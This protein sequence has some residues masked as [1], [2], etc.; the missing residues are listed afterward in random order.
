MYT[1][2]IGGVH[3]P[4]F[5][6][7]SSGKEI[8]SLPLPTKVFIG[9]SQHLGKP[10]KPLVKPKQEVRVGQLIGEADGFISANIHSSVSGVVK[11]VETMATAIGSL[12][13][14][15]VIDVDKEKT[16]EDEK[17]LFNKKDFNINELDKEYVLK[18]IKDAGIV[19]LGGATFPSNVKLSPPNGKAIEYLILNGAECEPYLTAD[20]RLMLKKTKEIIIGTEIIAKLLGVK[21]SFI[22]IE[23][24]K[25]D[26][27]EFF[28]KYLKEGGIK[29]IEVAPLKTKYPQGGEKQLIYAITKREVPSGKLPLDVGSVVHNVGTVFAVYEALHFDKPLFERV[30]TVTGAVKNPGNFLVR[31][32]TPFSFVIEQGAGGFIDIDN[33]CAVINGGPMMGKAVRSLSVPVLKGTSGILVLDKEGY[34]F[35]EQLPCLRCGKCVNVCPMG[36]MPTELAIYSLFKDIDNLADAMDCIECGSCSYICPSHRQLVHSIRIGKVL[37]RNRSKK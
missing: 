13:N 19:G 25:P 5:K 28:N 4:E 10:A 9:M 37:Y 33:V 2:K 31:V 22:G 34:K 26:A 36:L 30:V 18:A 27:I 8:V 16:L 32:G 20:H 17:L 29:N 3:P 7:K 23:A 12:D 6:S 24:N 15:V 11:K 35:K 1:F 14:T 21:K